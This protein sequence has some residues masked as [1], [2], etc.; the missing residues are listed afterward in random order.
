MLGY[1]ILGEKKVGNTLHSIEKDTKR[2]KKFS[3]FFIINIYSEKFT[4]K[5]YLYPKIKYNK[6]Q[7]YIISAMELIFFGIC[8]NVSK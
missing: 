7:I 2:L 5:L 1:M 4:K 8:T 6:L 3:H